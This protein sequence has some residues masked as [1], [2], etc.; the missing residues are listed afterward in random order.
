MQ[1]L[2]WTSILLTVIV[3]TAPLL[4]FL[5]AP[6]T[7]VIALLVWLAL[8]ACGVY[9]ACNIHNQVIT[10][11]SDKLRKPRRFVQ[12][13]DVH[14][15]SRGRK[16]IKKI[17]DQTN[18]LQP[19]G[20]FITGDLIDS[21]QVDASFLQPLGE[22]T[23]PA[24][25]CIGNHERYV[26]LDNAIDAIAQQQITVLRNECI[27][28]DDICLIGIDDADNANQ[29]AEQLPAIK[30]DSNKFQILLYH[31]PDGWEPACQQSVDLTLAGH[32]HGG[33]VWP[34][35]LL[36]KRQFPEL[37]GYFR[38]GL[39]HLYVSPGTGTWGPVLRFGTRSEMTII[40]LVPAKLVTARESAH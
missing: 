18:Q 1:L 37:Q 34:F 8:A 29:V 40:E 16:F 11:T 27:T 30:R 26:N 20:I 25:M 13:S 32:T 6:A 24:W 4:L 33:Q 2:G 12:L 7:G 36:V 28:M 23:S 15:G 10:I 17:V 3:L 39:S 31:K 21:S 38:R 19:D 35:G 22:L 9:A 5:S 14:A